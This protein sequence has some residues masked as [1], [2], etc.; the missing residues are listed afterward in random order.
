MID[1]EDPILPYLNLLKDDRYLQNTQTTKD[2]FIKYYDIRGKFFSCETFFHPKPGEPRA[3]Y[4]ALN[5]VHR[6]SQRSQCSATIKQTGTISFSNNPHES[7]T[8]QYNRKKAMFSSDFN[9]ARAGII[10][11]PHW[12]QVK[13][14]SLMYEK[15][16]GFRSNTHDTIIRN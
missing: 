10:N 3:I 2:S 7:I 1:Y 13:R 6:Y 5:D 15:L 11:D 16:N 9:F 4:T 14:N 8:E 12:E